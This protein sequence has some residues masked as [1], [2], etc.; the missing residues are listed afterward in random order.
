MD[1]EY[2]HNGLDKYIDQMQRIALRLRYLGL[3]MLMMTLMN[4]GSV[5]AAAVQLVSPFLVLQV[6]ASLFVLVVL[7]AMLFEQLRRRG[8]VIY[9]ELTDE[10]H[11]AH[12]EASLERPRI[13]FR[14]ALKN[15]ASSLELPLIPGR[16]GAS[17][18]LLL[19]LGVIVFAFLAY[20]IYR[21]Y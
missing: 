11:R 14:I 5:A 17:L 6:S 2:A 4:L 19:N 7:V 8:E 16:Y 9:G 1:P 3:V 18:Y 12:G 15:F 21:I 10:L 20:R 13:S